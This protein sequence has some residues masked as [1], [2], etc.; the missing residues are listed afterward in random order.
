MPTPLE[1]D[2]L[3]CL[4]SLSQVETAGIRENE[5]QMQFSTLL[6]RSRCSDATAPPSVPPSAPPAMSHTLSSNWACRGWSSNLGRRRDQYLI[7][8]RRAGMRTRHSDTRVLRLSGVGVGTIT[9]GETFGWG[10]PHLSLDIFLA[11]SELMV[12]CSR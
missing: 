1:N 11:C 12:G 9:T 2:L 7:F 5:N 8:D 4:W 3:L 6:L 10:L